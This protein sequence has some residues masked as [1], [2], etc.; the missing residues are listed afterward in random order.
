M[1]L[2]DIARHFKPCGPLPSSAT[3]ADRARRHGQILHALRLTFQDHFAEGSI[4][5]IA[6]ELAYSKFEVHSVLALNTIAGV[7]TAD[8]TISVLTYSGVPLAVITEAV[9]VSPN[10]FIVNMPVALEVCAELN[11]LILDR[12]LRKSQEYARRNFRSDA[13]AFLDEGQTMF[14]LRELCLKENLA[15]VAKN[16]RCF[17]VDARHQVHPVLAVGPAEF[18]FKIQQS[19][20]VTIAA[21]IVNVNPVEL[22]FE[23][24][25]DQGDLATALEA[26]R[27][28]AKT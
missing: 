4:D 10:A 6:A 15:H 24:L 28:K 11:A 1:N 21:G 9:L 22:M 19:V 12:R 8:D 16:H 5:L 18:N 17:Y 14:C 3:E 25:P 26:Y 27:Q 7:C 13:I 20:S 2:L 23:F